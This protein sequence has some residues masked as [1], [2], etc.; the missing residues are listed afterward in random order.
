MGMLTWGEVDLVRKLIV[1]PAARTKNGREHTL[2]LSAQALAILD[3]QPRRNST[4][5]V[6]GGQGFQNWSRGKEALD[7]RLGIAPWRLH[8]LR[9]TCATGM[10]DL[11]VLP[12]VIESVLNHVSGHKAGVAGTYNRAKYEPEMR[13]AL[14]K[15]GDHVDAITR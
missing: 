14:Q 5:F 8:D 6:F 1:L 4:G 15:W 12:H 2:P 9:R 11:G 13:G 10:A 3:R 7:Q